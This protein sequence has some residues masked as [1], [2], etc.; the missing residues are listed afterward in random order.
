MNDQKEDTRVDT[1]GEGTDSPTA[2]SYE[3]VET[4]PRVKGPYYVNCIDSGC[5]M[6]R[7][8]MLYSVG[9]FDN[10]KG[11]FI[12]IGWLSPSPDEACQVSDAMNMAYAAGHSVAYRDMLAVRKSVREAMDAAIGKSEGK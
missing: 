12:E 2:A 10:D 4:A 1:M 6:C 7:H 3:P 5:P 8:G 9:V 11:R